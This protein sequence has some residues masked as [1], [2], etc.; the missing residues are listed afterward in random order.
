MAKHEGEKE[1]KEKVPQQS[2]RSVC[3][4]DFLR[5]SS[6]SYDPGRFSSSSSSSLLS[7]FFLQ[8]KTTIFQPSFSAFFFSLPFA[9]R[10]QYSTA[11]EKRKGKTNQTLH[12][13]RPFQLNPLCLPPPSSPLLQTLKRAHRMNRRRTIIP[14]PGPY[15]RRRR[16]FFFFGVVFSLASYPHSIL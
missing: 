1:C 13:R 12:H 11:A 16:P 5:F 2:Y 15:R 3:G 7:I 4:G 9:G 6:S 14:P 8:L 10:S